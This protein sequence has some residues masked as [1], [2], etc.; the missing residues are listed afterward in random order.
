MKAYAITTGALFAVLALAH[1][2][3]VV[4]EWPGV[5]NSVAADAEAGVGLVAAGLAVWAWRLV[6]S[7]RGAGGGRA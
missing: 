1:V 5:L 6:R 2:A 3:R 7:A 4:D